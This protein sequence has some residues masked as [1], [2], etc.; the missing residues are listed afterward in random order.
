[1]STY[2]DKAPQ[3]PLSSVCDTL[4]IVVKEIRS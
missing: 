3:Q 2:Q 1:M 4:D